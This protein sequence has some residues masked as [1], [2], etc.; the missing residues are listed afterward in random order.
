MIDACKQHAEV[1]VLYLGMTVCWDCEIVKHLQAFGRLNVPFGFG[2]PARI[3]FPAMCQLWLLH[4]CCQRQFLG[5]QQ[6][7]VYFFI[8]GKQQ[9]LI[10]I[11]KSIQNAGGYLPCDS[12]VY[13]LSCIL[14]LEISF[15]SV[16][17]FDIH[18]I[19]FLV[20]LYGRGST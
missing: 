8:S 16:F 3:L 9:N 12:H 11:N 14:G 15:L 17:V 6:I 7:T 20:Q 13:A 19:S 2:F 10:N 4:F 18:C 1:K 5:N